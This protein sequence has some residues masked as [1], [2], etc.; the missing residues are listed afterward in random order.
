MNG[1]LD[2]V[3]MPVGLNTVNSP[4]DLMSR[5]IDTILRDMADAVNVR[6]LNGSRRHN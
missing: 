2:I 4:L 3:N 1:V 6:R 5:W